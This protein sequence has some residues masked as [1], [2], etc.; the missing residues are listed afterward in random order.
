MRS[1]PILASFAVLCVSVPH[2]RATAWRAPSAHTDVP[3]ARLMVR[4]ALRAAERGTLDRWAQPF[5]EALA[6]RS[7][8][9]RARFAMATVERLR[10][11]Y[12]RADS[13]YASLITIPPVA[14]RSAHADATADDIDRQARIGRAIGFAT[15][16]RV[17]DAHALA[18][19]AERDALRAAD[20]LGALDALLVRV[21]T[22]LRAEGAT[23][24]LRVLQRTDS[25]R[26][27]RDATIDAVAHCRSSGIYSRL[28]NR[29][30]ARRAARDG[31]AIAERADLQRIRASC[32]FTLATDFARTGLTDSLRGP[33]QQA[34]TLQQQTGDLA[35]LAASSQWAGYYTA[36]LGH[37]TA[38][39][40][41]LS[42]AWNAA[43]RARVVDVAAWTALN[44]GALSQSFFDAAS[45]TLWLSRA[46]SLMRVI[47]DAQGQVDVARMRATQARAAGNAAG[48]R[49]LLQ[50]AL[51]VAERI[52]EPSARLSVVAAQRDLEMS[53]GRLDEAE[54]LSRAEAALIDRY[55]MTG[56]EI[57]HTAT[58]AALALRRGDARAALP[59][60]D[61]ILAK[62]D[63][64]QHQFRYA[65]RLQ[66]AL[67]VGLLGD[68]R[69]AAR[70]A[71]DAAE[72]LD[73]WRATL[74]DSTFR[75]LAVQ[76]QRSQ[77]WYSASLTAFLASHGEEAV[78]FTIGE[79]RRAREFADR[80]ALSRSW[81]VSDPIVS[82]KSQ[83]NVPSM[84]ADVQ[85][86]LLDDRS[87][88]ITL[89]AGEGG[90]D[91]TAFVVT[92][93]SLTAHILPSATVLSPKVRRMLALLENGRDEGAESRALGA[94]LFGPLVDR[95]ERAG[96][97]RLV[98]V[99]EGGLN[100]VPFDLLRLADGRAVAE[101][102]ETA[103]VPSGAV[104]VGLRRAER[105]APSSAEALTMLALADAD[106]TAGA[107]VDSS[108][109]GRLRALL[110]GESSRLPRLPG[111]RTEVAELRRLF[112][113]A[114]VRAGA[115]AREGTVKREG[116]RY[117]VLHFA[118]HASVDEWSG[119][120]A[121]LAL[122]ASVGDDGLLESGEISALRLGGALVVLSA[123]HTV[124]GEIIA[125]E[126]VRG[127]ATAFLEAGA[128]SVMATAWRVNDR[129]IARV[130]SDFYVAL[131]NGERVSSALRS[132][133]RKA[134]ARGES[135]GVWGAFVLVGDP[136]RAVVRPS[137]SV[138]PPSKPTSLR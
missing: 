128:H 77:G 138:S 33:L 136:W 109:T 68:P 94:D 127:L 131:A 108:A 118:T 56:F 96:I 69:R 74:S 43:Q 41:H 26:P 40:Q 97:E 130:V 54:R 17:T 15:V 86:A 39:Q 79:R 73:R 104:F 95:L 98:I 62:L 63:P 28:G 105:R 10:Y 137:T 34:I 19:D 116:G 35:G 67:A 117:D 90:A 18:L 45:A 20:T 87:A 58:V 50:Q 42:V 123:C 60:L 6:R 78:A 23:A 30:A 119:A 59:L 88:L 82:S 107:P 114:V 38:A 71:L 100:R 84:L 89:E 53:E 32:L 2:G 80:L 111:A 1:W 125:G 22:T 37:F 57:S 75:L 4:D 99:P 21:A 81:R 76:S 55:R 134:M 124:G 48:A 14:A 46:D 3:S 133:R 83:Q 51:V 11:R 36:S 135:A 8:D 120:S 126:G 24:A 122:S 121:A 110:F 65:T 7:S 101:R 113:R 102:Y 25:L 27:S 29:V 47:N 13:L 93:Q 112:P 91:G 92:R 106:V 49:Q 44:R 103:V 72:T 12:A 70:E 52:G 61:Q 5:R 9:R 31:I 129:A 64:S 16:G 66:H 132:A 115:L 85:Q